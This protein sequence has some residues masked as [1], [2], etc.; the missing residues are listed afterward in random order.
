MILPSDS[1]DMFKALP[2]NDEANKPK[3]IIDGDERNADVLGIR[4]GQDDGEMQVA[5]HATT[6]LTDEGR[7]HNGRRWAIRHATTSIANGTGG[8]S[9]NDLLAGA[10][11]RSHESGSGAGGGKGLP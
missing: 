7:E 11:V 10:C 6:A 9:V 5:C 1:L 2:F 8:S 3:N 4:A